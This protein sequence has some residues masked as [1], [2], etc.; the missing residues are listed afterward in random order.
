MHIHRAS[1]IAILGCAALGIYSATTSAQQAHG[2]P[3]RVIVKLR[4]AAVAPGSSAQQVLARERERPNKAVR[5]S[6]SGRAGLALSWVRALADGS[7]VFTADELA[8]NPSA[9]TIAGRLRAAPEVSR[10]EADRP[11]IP[12]SIPTDP[13]WSHLWALSA[14]LIGSYGAD[15]ES[16]WQIQQGTS[17]AIVAVIDTGIL[18]HPD[19]VGPQG[20]WVADTSALAD[21]GY[22]FISDCR[23]RATCS[24]STASSLAAVEPQ[25]QALDRGDWISNADRATSFFSQC[26]RVPSSWHGT[27]TSGTVAALA[28]DEGIVGGAYGAKIVPVRVLGKCGGYLS[29]VA[30]AIRWAAGVHP[31]ISNRAPARIINLSL[32]A[33]GTCDA[34]MQSAIDA[35][36]AAGA[37]VVVAAGNEADDASKS[38]LPSCSNVIAVAATTKA[39]ELAYYS[40]YSSSHITLS[41]PGGDMRTTASAGIL[42]LSNTGTTTHDAAGWAYQFAQGSSMAAPHVSAAAALMLSRNSTLSPARLKTLLTAPSSVTPFPSSSR[43]ATEGVCGVGLLN[44]QRAVSNSLSPLRASLDTLDFGSIAVGGVAT[45]ELRITNESTAPIIVGASLLGG[46]AG[47]SLASDECSGAT[48]AASGSCHMQVAFSSSSEGV[49]TAT[50]EVPTNNGAEAVITTVQLTALAGSRLTSTT[51]S[52]TMSDWKIGETRRVTVTFQSR[53]AVQEQ[54]RSVYVSDAEQAAISADNCSNVELPAGSTCNV[55]VTITPV[56]VGSLVAQAVANTTG[57]QDVPFAITIAGE[58]SAAAPPPSSNDTGSGGS[59]SNNT[60]SSTTQSSG[61]GGGGLNPMYL[62][63]LASVYLLRRI[64][65]I[66]SSP[67]SR[68]TA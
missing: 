51:P 28:N 13:Y 2:L 18:P 55:E 17:G 11:V 35:A 33:T 31:T 46:T 27:H 56:R 54:L 14:P 41:A 23:I 59:S 64:C 34:T 68:H 38:M 30:E 9:E 49:G 67:S 66:S 43:C 58:V 36:T 16:A 15:F 40:N 61:G 4:P 48:L 26:S 32:G 29:D 21:E 12:Q 39:G 57:D 45:R 5:A 63:F 53:Y 6:L 7:H 24:A 47:F 50:L 10:A 42:S 1:S 37:L 3:A 20:I 65:S 60:P 62:L 25:P 22:D 8:A 19:M 52:I 44:A